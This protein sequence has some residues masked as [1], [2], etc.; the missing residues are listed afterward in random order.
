[1]E[2]DINTTSETELKSLVQQKKLE[3]GVLA[4]RDEGTQVIKISDDIVVKWG[5]LTASEVATQEFAYRNFDSTI[6]RVPKVYRYFH[7]ALD[8]SFSRGYL[9]MEYL[10]GWVLD[11]L[12]LAIHTDIIPRVTSIISHLQSFSSDV[13][14]PLEKGRPRG[15]IWSDDGARTVFHSTQEL[16]TWLNKRLEIHKKTIDITSEEL[17]FCHMDLCRRNMIMLPDRT[18]CLVDFGFAGF[19]PRFFEL[20]SLNYL[21]PCDAELTPPLRESSERVLKI[22]KK[23]KEMMQLMHRVVA[24]QLRFPYAFGECVENVLSLPSNDETPPPLPVLEFHTPEE[25]QPAFQDESLDPPR[26]RPPPP[27]PPKVP[28]R[29]YTLPSPPPPPQLP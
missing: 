4:G 29:S 24:V 25:V 10:N 20:V 15:Y 23:E 22:T 21:N 1:M 7:D 27:P 19:Y 6:C 28:H 14:G 3:Y 11:D 9:F 8:Q 18:I 16:N 26:P 12:D 13:P 2:F 17:V 5:S